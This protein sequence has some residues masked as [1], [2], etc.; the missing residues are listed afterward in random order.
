M[1][2]PDDLPLWELLTPRQIATDY[3]RRASDP[4]HSVWVSASAGTGKTKVLI[5]RV[6]RLLLPRTDGTAGTRPD[7]ILCLTYT[8]AAAAEMT[9]RLLD[10]LRSWVTQPE[11]KL[12]SELEM[13]LGT[14]VNDPMVHAARK[15]F[16]RIVDGP[17]QVRTMTLHAFCQ[18][19]LARFPLEAGVPPNFTLIDDIMQRQLMD[20][21]RLNVVLHRSQEPHVSRALDHVAGHIADTTFSKFMRSM[22]DQQQQ[23][24]TA[25]NKIPVYERNQSMNQAFGL[26]KNDNRDTW[27]RDMND[28][29]AEFDRDLRFLART[30]GQSD[31]P[32]YLGHADIIAKW[33]A[34]DITC[35]ADGLDEILGVFLTDKLTLRMKEHKFL[36]KRD[37]S[38]GMIYE[39]CGR[40]LQHFRFRRTAFDLI[41]LNLDLFIVAEAILK[42]YRCLK[43]QQG[44]L[45]FDD[46]I[47]YTVD[48]LGARYNRNQVERMAS[49]VMYK[50]DGG[51][52]HILLDESQDTNPEQ[53]QIIHALVDEFFS[54]TGARL[55]AARTLFVVG[56]LKQSIYSFRGAD[57]KNFSNSLKTLENRT[58][59]S[60]NWLLQIPLAVSFRSTSAVLEL[61]DRVFSDPERAMELEIDQELQH[62]V[63][64]EGQGG[65]V[66]LWPIISD[67]PKDNNG[68]K[69]WV[70]PTQVLDTNNARTQLAQKIAGRIRSW[71]DSGTILPAHNRPIEPRDILILVRARKYVMPEILAA[72][73]A[74][75]IP[76]SGRDRLQPTRA[77]A[78]Q[79]VMALIRFT[80]LPDDDLNLACVLK[81][82]FCGY[83]DDDLSRLAP[84]REQTLWATIQGSKQDTAVVSYLD[85]MKSQARLVGCYAF[86]MNVLHQP[87]PTDPQGSGLRALQKRLSRDVREPLAELQNIVLNHES[88]GGS[89]QG[90]IALLENDDTELK[91]DIDNIDNVVRLMTVH[92]AKGL[93]APIVILPDT[94]AK[95]GGRDKTTLFWPEKTG[96]DLPIWIPK[97]QDQTEDLKFL[98][99][100]EQRAARAESSRLLYVALTRPRDWLIVAGAS[101]DDK[102]DPTS[103]YH[104]VAQT[105]TTFEHHPYYQRDG[106]VQILKCPQIA[107]PDGVGYDK[108]SDEHQ[109]QKSVPAKDSL[110]LYG[111]I[112]EE[113]QNGRP[114]RPERASGV[115]EAMSP[116]L[117][118]HDPYRFRRGLLTHKLL[119]VLPDID[120][121]LRHDIAQ[122]FMQRHGVDLPEDARNGVV[123]EVLSIM[124]HP[125]FGVVF[126]PGSRAE[127]PI[128]GMTPDGHLV[129]GQIDRLVVLPGQVLVIDYKTNR[130]PPL[131]DTQI[132]LTYRQQMKAYRDLLRRIYPQH[133]VRSALLW[134]D[135]PRLMPVADNLL[136]G[137]EQ[138]R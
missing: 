106:D 98:A 61:V 127:V 8:K 39:T 100:A 126:G 102:V 60:E 117:L 36:I 2:L 73:R 35:C 103:W 132:P 112:A 113:S 13:L 52:D 22:F 78:V 86:V 64:R 131:N 108:K 114:L 93:E 59:I 109:E 70:L 14:T 87:C 4:T 25:L 42:N 115:V 20:Q 41:N 47:R 85:N 84:S 130:P 23:L 104:A 28:L 37:N 34:A 33:L 50:L 136:E 88:D 128:T 129:S 89:L 111:K 72:L 7:R 66:E 105:F 6:L 76:V 123:S 30:F 67:P 9:N 51:L 121:D 62:L 138:V 101:K 44:V 99:D 27:Q 56:D 116:L 69:G 54:G 83:T 137:L 94:T 79:D 26:D 18:S 80:L 5:E 125:D 65:Q 53:W 92:G 57:V 97:Q 74:Q 107:E 11:D 10:K 82:P 81:S 135:G 40:K 32:T 133:I 45:D 90:L 16:S 118:V 55:D 48:L 119:Q 43:L 122:K 58:A 75:N 63:S 24:I 77:L 31:A 124:R 96:L 12:K 134:T 46:L 17:W 49:W 91:R 68:D 95:V 120:D 1:N 19:I 29:P 21:A 110:A 38:L 71:L 3:Q 15:L